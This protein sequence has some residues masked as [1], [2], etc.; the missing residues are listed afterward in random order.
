[1]T[2]PHCAQIRTSFS[3]YLDCAVSGQEMQ[4]I[5]RHL[6]ECPACQE[7]FDGLRSMQL[8]L[9]S[10]GPAKAPADL[11]MKLRLAISH[12]Q[13]A[14]KARWMDSVSVKWENA[15]RPLLV[16]VSA[17]FAGSVALVGSIMMLLGMVAAPQT[18]MANDEPLGAM[19]SPHYLYSADTPRAIEGNSD[20]AIVVEAYVNAQGRV[21]DYHIV[22]G[23]ANEAVRSQVA[24]Q[25]LLSVFEPARVFGAPVRSMVV[26][27]YSGIS[28]RG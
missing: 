25:L 10:L 23:Q 8:T 13:A 6:E 19:T 11:G 12:E 5:A 3:S 21:Y 17:G 28:V 9:A 22:S 1:M 20:S 15:I 7:E 26:V 14:A 27:T 24:G 18:V 16:Q 2:S 4:K